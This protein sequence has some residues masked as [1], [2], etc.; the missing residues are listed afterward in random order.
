MRGLPAKI[1]VHNCYRGKGNRLPSTGIVKF[2]Y[3]ERIYDDGSRT[4]IHVRNQRALDDL[5]SR[6][7]TRKKKSV[8]LFKV[9]HN[10]GNVLNDGNRDFI[11]LLRE[12]NDEETSQL[13]ETEL[14]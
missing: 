10:E 8:S 9:G 4:A 3:S 11:K 7:I 12:A 13:L 2:I 14:C 1:L 6:A 5:Q